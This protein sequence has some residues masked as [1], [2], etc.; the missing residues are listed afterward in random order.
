MDLEY[1]FVKA[2]PQ[3]NISGPSRHG[4]PYFEVLD[5]FGLNS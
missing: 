2:L 5:V 4:G 1:E 3:C